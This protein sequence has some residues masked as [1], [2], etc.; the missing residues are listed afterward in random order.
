LS[1]GAGDPGVEEALGVPVPD[2]LV[3]GSMTTLGGS[4]A[5]D[6]AKAPVLGNVAGQVIH[7][8]RFFRVSVRPDGIIAVV[9]S[10]E[11]S[12][13]LDAF[14]RASEELLAVVRTREALSR[15]VLMD[16][17]LAPPRNDVQFEDAMRPYRYFMGS[18]PH[19]IA[20]LVAT[21]AGTLQLQR[22]GGLISVKYSVFRDEDEAVAY[23]LR[24]DGSITM[25]LGGGA[26]E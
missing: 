20:F 11:R 25:P 23:L 6:T 1:V 10:A 2:T 24:G 3:G 7:A 16:F 4:D 26:R 14:L 15:G 9:R 12:D 19:K 17:R 21:V 13:D 5:D 18:G 8:D 22:L